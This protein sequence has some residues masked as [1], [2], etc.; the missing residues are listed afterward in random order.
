MIYVPNYFFHAQ[1]KIKNFLVFTFS[2]MLR[3][4]ESTSLFYNVILHLKGTIGVD[5]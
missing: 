5:I 3:G 4:G 1:N 2:E